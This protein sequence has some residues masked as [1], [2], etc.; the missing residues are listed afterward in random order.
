[1]QPDGA[2]AEGEMFAVTCG[3]GIGEAWTTAAAARKTMLYFILL[4][5]F[6]KK[7]NDGKE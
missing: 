2:A 7:T 3:F 5:E 4:D 1:M 6:W